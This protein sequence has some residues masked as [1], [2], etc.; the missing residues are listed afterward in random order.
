MDNKSD[1]S[2]H[3]GWGALKEFAKKP[4][5]SEAMI[6]KILL[7]A[8]TASAGAGASMLLAHDRGLAVLSSKQED[9]KDKYKRI[10]D[11]LDNLDSEVRKLSVQIKNNH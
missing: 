7:A 9:D 10:L 3:S 1:S 4:R 5:E 11:K 8:L 6:I 2:D